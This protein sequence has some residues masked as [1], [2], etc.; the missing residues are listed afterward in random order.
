M[1]D[2]WSEYYK[3][4]RNIRLIASNCK[5]R[6]VIIIRKDQ[7]RKI[8]LRPL[9]IFKPSHLHFWIE[10]LKLLETPFDIYISNASVKIP[11]PI[12]PDLTELK[13]VRKKL[14]DNFEKW[15]TGYDIFVDVDID[16]M[17]QRKKAKEYGLI[18]QKRLQESGYKKTKLWDTGRGFH[19][20]DKGKFSPDFVKELVMELCL[21]YN[22][23]MSSPVKI[24]DGA[25]YL[26]DYKTK[27]WK[28]LR[29]DEE[30]PQT[31]KP[32]IDTSIYDIRRIRR[33]PYSLHSKTGKPMTLVKE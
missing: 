3:N 26:A 11:F 1:L 33:V 13:K 21:Q 30:P 17:Q 8:T 6:E 23:P 14:N 5:Y 24:I 19:I 32:N 22:I 12:P 28:K 9:K 2:G 10:R 16:D 4:I 15:L 25:K 18:L 20:V 27:R 31:P 29:P 7:G